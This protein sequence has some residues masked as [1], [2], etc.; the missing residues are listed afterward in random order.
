MYAACAK[1]TLREISRHATPRLQ[2]TALCFG[3]CCLESREQ[4]IGR[5]AT[6]SYKM[7]ILSDCFCFFAGLVVLLGIRTRDNYAESDPKYWSFPR[8]QC[9]PTQASRSIPALAGR[10][11]SSL[12]HL[13]SQLLC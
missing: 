11:L 2:R 1:L 7:G 3:L 12:A 5:L 4:M 8:K 9:V 13:V 6:I 10:A